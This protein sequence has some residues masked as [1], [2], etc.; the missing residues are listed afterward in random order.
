MIFS[1]INKSMKVIRTGK[2]PVAIPDY[3]KFYLNWLRRAELTGENHA[4]NEAYRL[5]RLTE[6]FGLAVIEDD[7]TM[8]DMI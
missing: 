7:D 4:Y 5:A 3:Y 8:E 2:K 1:K 6:E